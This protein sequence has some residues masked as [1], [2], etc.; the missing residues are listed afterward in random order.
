SRGKIVGGLSGLGKNGGDSFTPGDEKILQLFAGHISIAIENAFIFNELTLEKER[1][2]TTLKSIGDAVITT[3]QSG[4]ITRMNPIA[5]RLTGWKETEALK[6]PL[7][8][9]FNIYNF[10]TQQPGENLVAKVMQTG[11]IIGLENHTVL[12]SR[13]DHEYQITDS[14]APIYDEKMNIQGVILVFRDITEEHRLQNDLTVNQKRLQSILDNSP[15]VIYIKDSEGRYQ[16]IN[17]QFEKL[18]NISM[19]KIA[20]LTD[21]DLFPQELADIYRENDLNVL[22]NKHPIEV[23]EVASYGDGMHRY[24]SVKFPL[25]DNDSHANAICG[26]STDITEHRKTEEALRRSQKMDAIGQLSGGIAHDFNNQLGVISGYLEMISMHDIDNDFREQ[27]L[28]AASTATQRCIDLTRQL[29]S[30]SRKQTHTTE[31]VNITESISD[32]ATVIARSVTPSI[33]VKYELSNDVCIANVDNGEFQD[34]II[35]LILN[36]KDAMPSGGLL[37][38]KSELAQLDDELLTPQH[39]NSTNYVLV[40]IEDSGEGMSKETLEHV[41]EPFFTT[42]PVGRGTGLG[43][44]MVYGFANRHKGFVKIYSEPGVGTSIKL[45]MPK[46]ESFEDKDIKEQENKILA[47]GT[48]TILVVDDEEQLLHLTQT[49]LSRLG[50]K[51]FTASNAKQALHILSKEKG[52]NLLFSDIVMPGM[53]GYE[54]AK[55]AKEMDPEIKILMTSGFTSENIQGNIEQEHAKNLLNKPY[56]QKDLAQKVRDTLDEK[57]KTK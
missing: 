2:E 16:L 7:A 54:L 6:L 27:C 17:K 21:Y 46:S 34:A 49:S 35:N 31:N 19:D 14:A 51:I 1:A 4:L 37:V 18:F 11:D 29:L 15:A 30:F 3:D 32:I 39:E 45:Y 25:L 9:I 40:T 48:E 52:I 12:K 33:K 53:N 38:I 20:G 24:L 10:N 28:T 8:D 47:S 22:N 50:Y 57:I 43:L 13:D 44:A 5:E 23:E 55:K 56:R 26:I 42:K 36:A 41:F